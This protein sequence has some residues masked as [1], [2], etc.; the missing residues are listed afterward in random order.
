MEWSGVEW[1]G[2]KQ[3]GS[4]QL[5]DSSIPWFLVGCCVRSRANFSMHVHFFI[6]IFFVWRRVV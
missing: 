5:L 4:G 1:S 6:G 2:V 3:W